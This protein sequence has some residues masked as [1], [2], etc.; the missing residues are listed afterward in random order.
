MRG[1]PWEYV[2]Y[3]DYLRGD[4]KQARSALKDLAQVADM[5]KVLG[6]YPAA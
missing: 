1:R 4:D 2:F 5:V 6:I 3:A